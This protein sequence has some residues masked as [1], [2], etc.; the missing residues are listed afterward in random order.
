MVQMTS[1]GSPSLHVTAEDPS[2]QEEKTLQTKQRQHDENTHPW[3]L[4]YAKTTLAVS[5]QPHNHQTT[6]LRTYSNG[7][8]NHP[9]P[10]PATPYSP[11]TS[12]SFLCTLLLW[13]RSPHFIHFY[14]IPSQDQ[15]TPPTYHLLVFLTILSHNCPNV[16]ICP[17]QLRPCLKCTFC[18]ITS[19]LLISLT[20]PSMCN[21]CEKLARDT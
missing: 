21:P 19:P 13:K 12:P 20:L 10:L 17:T 3:H 15:Y 11:S 6:Y 5:P 1:T 7:W 2:S 18:S 8:C 9:Q 4:S 16:K 14:C